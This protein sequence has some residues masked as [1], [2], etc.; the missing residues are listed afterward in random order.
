MF[1]IRVMYPKCKLIEQHEPGIRFSRQ[2]A[3]LEQGTWLEMVA[4]L[5]ST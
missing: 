1:T 4:A 5:G 3:T 2:G